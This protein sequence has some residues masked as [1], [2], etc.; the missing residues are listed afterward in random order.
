MQDVLRRALP[1]GMAGLLAAVRGMM[2]PMKAFI[3]NGYGG[4]EVMAVGHMPDPKPNHGEIVVEVRASSVNPVDWKVRDGAMRMLTGRRF[5]KVFGG[6]LAGV[7]QALGPEVTR[8]ALGDSVYGFTPIVFRKPGAH[9]EKVAVAAKN[10]RRLPP[11]LS[12][13]QAAAI[14]VAALTAL[15]GLGQCGDLHGKTV[16]VNGATGGVGH[17]AVQLAKAG[18][19][20]VTAVCSARNAERAKAL[21]AERVIDYKTHDFTCDVQRYAVVFDAFGALGFATASRA[22]ERQGIYVTTLANP[23]LFARSIWRNFVG[24][25]RICFA[26]MRDK[27]QDYAEIEKHLAA[28]QVAPVVDRVFSLDQAAEAYAASEAGGTV[29][30]I[31]IRVA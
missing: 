11:G 10:L 6:D 15:N 7:V 29:G 16:I 9:A 31:V 4:P 2:G 23:A 24:G 26:N 12:Y 14:P 19:A 25:Q 18:G 30:K 21:G 3:A 5:P 28:G 22:L 1:T 17:F 27:E 20:K 13:E 8:F